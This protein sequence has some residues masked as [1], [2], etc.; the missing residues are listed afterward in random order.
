MDP[1]EATRQERKTP[2]PDAHTEDETIKETV[3]GVK[4]QANCLRKTPPH[5]SLNQ[6]RLR[7]VVIASYNGG[8]CASQ[9]RGRGACWVL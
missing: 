3:R 1:S 4:L 5:S 8:Y 9:K 2:N 6:S 7:P